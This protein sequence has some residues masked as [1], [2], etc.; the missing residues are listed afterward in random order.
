MEGEQVSS[1]SQRI[2]V[3]EYGSDEWVA[4]RKR[5]IGASDMA[6]IVGADKWKG[7]YELALEK[8]G[9][10]EP[11]TGNAATR[12]GH[13][14]EGV[15][16]D[17]YEAE[18][19]CEVIRGETWIDRRYPHLW[20]TLDGRVGKRGVEVKATTRW[21]DPPPRVLVQAFGQMA[22]AD[23]D[24]VD[25]VRVS[26]YG[27]PLVTT[28]ERDGQAC[29]DLLETCE[30]WYVKYVL[31]DELPAV[32]GSRSASLHLD[33]VQGPPDMTATDE[34]AALVARLQSVRATLAESETL[35]RALVNRIKESMVG[36]YGLSGHGFR[37]AWKPQKAR[38][39]V[40]WKDVAAHWQ[41]SDDWPTVV[42]ANTTTSR[43]SRPFRLTRNEEE[44]A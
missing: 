32:D 23:L 14:I 15:A 1:N 2:E 5:G 3:P 16:L 34:Q 8:R 20:A 17:A 30:A 39:A 7:E 44:P 12:W 13:L 28:I 40:A 27:A 41:S 24:S 43:G 6:A 33:T 29:R 21:T 36:A 25:I 9:E 22:L 37:I 18:N 11:F 42:A 38:E 19:H 10:T 35:E 4:Q 31:G 26:P